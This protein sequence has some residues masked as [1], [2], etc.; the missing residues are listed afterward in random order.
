MAFYAVCLDPPEVKDSEVARAIEDLKVHVPVA[1]RQRAGCVAAF[2]LAPPPT[3]FIINDKGI[4][5]HCEAGYTPE[6]ARLLSQRIDKVLAG[7]D[8]SPRRAEGSTKSKSTSSRSTPSRRTSRTSR[9]TPARAS[10]TCGCREA[11]IAPRTEPARLKLTPLWKCTEVKSPGNVARADRRRAGAAAA[12]GR[13]VEVAGRGGL[14]RQ[15][16]RPAHAETAPEEFIGCLRAAAGADGR[17]YVVA[18]FWL[19]QRCHVLDENWKR[20][21]TIRKT[22]CK[23]PTAASPTCNWATWRAT[24]N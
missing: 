24:G 1:P 8:I 2:N 13:G 23:T 17:R 5:Q 9:P 7:E 18:F 14:G 16:H 4:V 12:G 10:R 22:P 3:T 19:Q 21:P 15:A 20:W 11:K 6:F